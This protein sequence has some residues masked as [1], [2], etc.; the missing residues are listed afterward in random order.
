MSIELTRLPT[1]LTVVTHRM[2]HLESAALGVWV[3][4]GARSEEN[5]EHG[6]SHLL[7][8]MAFKGTKT[9]SAT[10]IAE[11][12][13]AVG[14]DLN[15]ATSVET[16][17]YHARILKADVPLALDILS[18]IL[19]RSVFDTNELEREKHV[20][21]QEIGAAHDTPEDR[22]YDLLVEG[23]FPGQPIGR[24]ILGTTETVT[25][26]QPAAIG[27]YLD[28]HYRGPTMV[29]SAAGAVDHRQLV[30]LAGAG[31]AD[32]I[33]DGGPKPLPA[34]YRGG[35]AREKRDLMEAQIMLGFEGRAHASADFHTAQVLAGLLGGGM[36]SRLFQE[37]RERR[38]LCYSIYSFHWSFA[39]SGLFGIHAATSEE[40]VAGLVPVILEELDKV[41]AG[42]TE[43]EVDRAKAQ[44]RAGLLMALENPGA[45]AGQMARQILIFGKLIAM[46][47]LVQ[48]IDSV[49]VDK[50]RDLAAAIFAGSPPTVAAVGPIGNL[51]ERGE[52]ARRLGAPLAA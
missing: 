40:D 2:D 37:V 29:V 18:D 8:H 24:T 1:G 22:A 9:R 20:I 43:A 6:I 27:R 11:Q 48:R 19:R 23:A 47:E 15:A 41:T 52:I 10:D 5:D 17:S 12:I 34:T 50:V 7:E 21:V 14:G 13:E 44:M 31:F 36:S 42:V 51:L 3:R 45:R 4:A 49:T 28:R 16:T 35:E 38:G 39:D 26:F 30:E 33:G 46:E 25:G 32:L